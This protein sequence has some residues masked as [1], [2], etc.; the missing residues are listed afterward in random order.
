MKKRN[1]VK[2]NKDY[3]GDSNKGYKFEWDGHDGIIANFILNETSIMYSVTIPWQIRELVM[4]R[5]PLQKV[6]DLTAE[7]SC[8]GSKFLSYS[9]PWYNPT[10]LSS[11]PLA[12]KLHHAAVICCHLR[13]MQA[14][15]L[16]I[17]L[18]K[19]GSGSNDAGIRPMERLGSSPPI[20]HECTCNVCI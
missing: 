14:A 20:L 8:S 10:V 5:I 6:S 2:N 4:Q 11:T 7:P 15:P 1:H 16:K 9:H 17:V 12:P 3:T 13:L 18:F 19:Q